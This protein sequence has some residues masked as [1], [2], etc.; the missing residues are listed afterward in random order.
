MKYK[1][2]KQALLFKVDSLINI[3]G[4]ISSKKRNAP[5]FLSEPNETVSLRK[6]IISL[7]E[8]IYSP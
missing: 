4:C 8:K 5:I 7:K 1:H 6:K 3:D 2:F